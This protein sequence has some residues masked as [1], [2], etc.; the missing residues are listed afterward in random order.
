[1]F[2]SYYSETPVFTES[3]DD[4]KALRLKIYWQ[5]SK[6]IKQLMLLLG[7]DVPNKM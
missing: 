7:I 2:N 3:N 1:M 6:T 4:V 5:V